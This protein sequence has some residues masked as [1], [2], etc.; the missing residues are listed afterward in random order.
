MSETSERS[1]LR[2]DEVWVEMGGVRF[3]DPYRWLED[4]MLDVLAWQHRQ[5]AETFGYLR[6]LPYFERLRDAL[7]EGPAAMQVGA[8]RRHGYH[9]FRQEAPAADAPTRLVVA[10]SPS[11]EGRVLV[12]PAAIDPSAPPTLDWYW[13]SP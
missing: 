4:D 9:W 3:A 1:E 8:P 10:D 5:D 2:R 6:S 12:D 7:E 13:P 11:A